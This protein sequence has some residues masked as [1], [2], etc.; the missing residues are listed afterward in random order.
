[1]SMTKERLGEFLEKNYR[2]FKRYLIERFHTLSTYDAEDIVQQTIVKLLY[3]DADTLSI[4]H[5][6]AYMNTALHN[7]AVDHFKKNSRLVYGLED[8]EVQRLTPEDDVLRL[9]RQQ[10]LFKALAALDEKSRYILVETEF[11][12]RSY[13]ALMAETGEKLGTLLSRKSRAK[14]KLYG[15][16]EVYMEEGTYEKK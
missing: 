3:K 7:G 8:K 5:L 10:M 1:M 11:K 16:L 13:E 2:F 12:G 15:L 14:K 4:R 6:S 9:E